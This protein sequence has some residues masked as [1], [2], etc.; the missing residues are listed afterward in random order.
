LSEN[1]NDY[2]FYDYNHADWDSIISHLDNADFDFLFASD[3][4]VESIFDKFYSILYECISLYVPLR[5]T[6][7]KSSSIKYPPSISR[8]L[9]KKSTAWRLYRQ[10]GT[11]ES[12][13]SYNRLAAECRTAIRTH[14]AQQEER[15]VDNGNLGAFYRYANNKFS[16]KS[17][18]GALKNSNGS[19]TNDSSTKAELLQSV[20]I[21]KFTVDNGIIPPSSASKTHS[22]LNNITFSSL[23][24][25]RVIKRLKIKTKGG[26]D[27][28]PPIFLKKCVLQ[29]STPLAR[30]FY[31][32]FESGFL[33]LDWL[34]SYIMPLFKKGS[35]YDP[36]NYRPIAL[37][38][39]MCKLMES[40][41]KD[42]LLGFL[43]LK[44]IINK[45]QH[46]FISNHS[47]GT[48][49]L[50]CTHDWLVSLNLSHTTDIIYI[51]FSRAFDSIVHNK[52]LNKLYSY[53]ITG[54][55][56]DWIASFVQNRFQC[57]AIENCF[58]SAAKV[59]S[60]VPQ[61]SVLGPIL[62][63]IF[64]NDIDS[65]CHGQTNIKLFADDAKLYS[66]IDLNDRSV[67]LQ[68]SLNNLATWADVW[69][70][71]INVQKCCVLST[72][73]NNRTSHTCSNSYYLNGVL[74]VNKEQVLDLGITISADLSYKAHIN[75]IVAKALQRS[76]TFF[77]GFASRNLQLMR[78]AFVT[79]I[80]P[81]LEYNSI[82]WSPN[83]VHLIELIESVQR[84][85]TKRITSLS[86]LSYSSR[87]N[88]LNLQSL[89]LRRLLIDLTNY[90]KIFNGMSPITPTDY[91]LTYNPISS[92]RSIT[93]SLLK[94]L[95]A[96]SQ[97]SSSFFYRSVDAWNYLPPN[98]KLSTSLKSFKLAIKHVDL[99]AF[100]KCQFLKC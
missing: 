38:A 3:Q 73:R 37:T 10:F 91:F 81:I 17:A 4:P 85:F 58:S 36:A 76:S 87:L 32:S 19:I 34:R 23:L 88:M 11:P 96:S 60:G 27:G 45:N 63:I 86:S 98:I 35:R 69:Q 93:P 55:L 24:V 67:S 54:K 92:T 13:S 6:H 83:L 22:K 82:V 78:K 94:P 12:R 61:G 57:V 25:H 43:L 79:Y 65:V 72:V 28:I 52:L 44:G 70:L 50:E 80:R 16:F 20:F 89:E 62:F 30:L 8:K 33:P 56:L 48:N 5:V 31:C 49:L 84:K 39:T 7:K 18:I 40:V 15:L 21:N 42:Q 97:L 99:S 46:G 51:D 2:N 74:L 53:G 71:S 77:R 1:N 75:N 41:I 29:L 95:H 47:T 9:R 64:I 66:E 59:I 26:P 68:T 90:F 100:L 14:L